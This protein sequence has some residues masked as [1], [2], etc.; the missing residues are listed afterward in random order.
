MLEVGREPAIATSRRRLVVRDQALDCR[1]YAGAQV[2]RNEEARAKKN[3]IWS[4]PLEFR[5]TTAYVQRDPVPGAVWLRSVRLQLGVDV[6]E[7]EYVRHERPPAN[8]Q[9]RNNLLIY[10]SVANASFDQAMR[11]SSSEIPAL[12]I[13][14]RIFAS[15]ERFALLKSRS[16]I[17]L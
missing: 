7:R 10:L 15:R 11:L 12:S 1:H 2:E 3:W 8:A 14:C 17:S 4:A 13:K 9:L 5:R 16:S 6:Y